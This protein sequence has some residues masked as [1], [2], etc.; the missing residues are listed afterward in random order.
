MRAR[1]LKA[2]VCALTMMG[3]LVGCSNNG[4]YVSGDEPD[5]AAAMKETTASMEPEEDNGPMGDPKE[6]S[7]AEIQEVVERELLHGG[8]LDAS[9]IT[10][11]VNEGIVEL[12]GTARHLLARDRATRIAQAIKGVRSVS[13]RVRL[14]PG[15]VTRNALKLDVQGA[16]AR[17]PV[18]SSYEVTVSATDGNVIQLSGEVASWHEMKLVER[19]A[20]RV[21]GVMGVEN[22]LRVTYD[23]ERSPVEIKR[24]V[25]DRL[26][27]D[28]LVDDAFITVEVTDDTVRLSGVVESAAARSV[29][30]TDAWVVGV[31][32]VDA[33]KLEINWWSDD[34]ARQGF[35]VM[36]D[37]AITEAIK[38]AAFYDPRV[39]SAFIRPQ[40]KHGVVTLEGSVSSLKASH[41]A[42][43]LARN[44]TGVVY[45]ENNLKIKADP[46]RTDADIQADVVS[47]LALN[48]ITE[49]YEV[50]VLV[51][52][53]QVTL[54]GGV[55]S[56]VEKAEAED[57]ASRT[58]G[59][60]MVENELEVEPTSAALT[61]DS[62]A[63]PYTPDV[64]AWDIY[65]P[66]VTKLSDAELERRIESELFWDPS[67]D[68]WDIDVTV[69]DGEAI[70]KGT[71]D[72][73]QEKLEAEHNALEGGAL[74]VDNRIKVI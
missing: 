54:Q 1:E 20:K 24:S 34:A 18:A 22:D 6:L 56:F 69:D 28:A 45:V 17:D 5:G 43:R 41:A 58:A 44:T 49:S 50:S 48:P 61:Y 36:P 64:V 46:E 9:D 73:Y 33:S 35:Q 68:S 26:A 11:V 53:G 74:V 14:Q 57:V 42:E 71:A 39:L 60:W 7:D 62:Y 38:D 19:L 59:V 10:V 13:N 29:A 55:D 2:I 65:V 63:Y 47:N 66:A 32:D 16:L 12:T 70:L 40:V 3:A 23:Q 37:H 8:V 21:R 4:S 27:W 25:E 52:D 15:E 30:I 72:T 31:S 67:V 51:D